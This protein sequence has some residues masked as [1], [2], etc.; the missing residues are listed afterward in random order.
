MPAI[1]MSNTMSVRA[2]RRLRPLLATVIVALVCPLIEVAAAASDSTVGA[3]V[4]AGGV[5]VVDPYNP[6]E[7]LTHG[8]AS[9]VFTVRLPDKSTCPGDSA[10]DQWR[11]GSYIV[12][13]ADDPVAIRYG[14]VGPEPVGNGRYALFMVD[15]TPFVHQLTMRNAVRGQ[16]GVIPPMPPFDF[17]VVAGEKIPDG[18][19]RIGVACTYFGKTAEYWDTQIAISGSG[20][21]KGKLL[22]RL[23]DVPDTVFASGQ[24]SGRST[25]MIIVLAAG[26]LGAVAFCMYFWRHRRR[27]ITTL[28]KERS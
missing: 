22:W 6:S 5:V 27:P 24:G 1:E 12:P 18:R 19:Y 28:S 26:G 13:T 11:V 9:T 4:R 14:A 20:V 10:N 25:L 15:T 3:P 7:A 17:T 23:A 16:P 8:S 2:R 21:T